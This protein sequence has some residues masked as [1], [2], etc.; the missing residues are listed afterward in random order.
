MAERQDSN[1]RAARLRKEANREATSADQ[2]GRDRSRSKDDNSQ[3]IN[4]FGLYEKH[5]LRITAVFSSK[6]ET[7]PSWRDQHKAPDLN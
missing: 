2:R 6:A 7:S 5:T 3:H 4:Q 1:C